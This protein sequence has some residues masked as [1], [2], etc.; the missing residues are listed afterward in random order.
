MPEST[1]AQNIINHW[2]DAC[3]RTIQNY[4]HVAHMNLISEDVQVFG[5]P[6]FEVI[7]YQ[8]WYAQ[9]EHEFSQRLIL[10]AQ[11]EGMKIRQ[12]NE[13]RIMFAT[14]ESI[15]AADKSVNKQAIEVVLAKEID[16]EW[17]VIQ[18]RL[19]S[20]DEAKHWGIT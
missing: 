5:V 7:G 8:D 3:S 2:I 20:T 6:G 4:D 17:R 18:E 9:S 10:D 11:Y 19:L 13:S 12:E 14:M 1:S 16:G 15:T